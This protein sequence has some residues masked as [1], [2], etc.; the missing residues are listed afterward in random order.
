MP[1]DTQTIQKLAS[2]ELLLA[3][4]AKFHARRDMRRP[5]RRRLQSLSAQGGLVQLDCRHL[6]NSGLG[7]RVIALLRPGS[8]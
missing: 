1:T 7:L 8:R 2:S 4:L 5:A 6:N 3:R